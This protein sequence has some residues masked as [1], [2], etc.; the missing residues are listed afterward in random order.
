MWHEHSRE[1]RML[2][3]AP[4]ELMRLL[5]LASACLALL[6]VAPVAAQVPSA[7]HDRLRQQA[8]QLLETQSRIEDRLANLR[9]ISRAL[10]EAHLFQNRKQDVSDVSISQ[11]FNRSEKAAT[12]V[13]KFLAAMTV[14]VE[15]ADESNR[16]RIAPKMAL[17]RFSARLDLD[18]CLDDIEAALRHMKSAPSANASAKELEKEL[19]VAQEILRAIA[20]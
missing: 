7:Q 19:R 13:D 16:K 4:F 11:V 10:Y 5:S 15:I 8:N 17:L 18:N 3:S 2:G 6:V 1:L 14:Y 20:F 9:K 12:A